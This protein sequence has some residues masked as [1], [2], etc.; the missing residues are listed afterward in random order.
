M[1]ATFFLLAS[2]ALV[3]LSDTNAVAQAVAD[4]GANVLRVEQVDGSEWNDD[5]PRRRVDVLPANLPFRLIAGPAARDLRV[6]EAAVETVTTSM[7]IQVRRYFSERGVLAPTVQWLLRRCKPGVTNE[8]DYLSPGAH[9]LVWRARDFDLDALAKTS[10]MMSSNSIP[11]IARLGLLYEEYKVSPIRRAEPLVDYPDPRAE[12]WC[13]TPYGIAIALRA[14]ENRRKFR[15]WASS[16]PVRDRNVNYRW[17]RLSP[18][19]ASASRVQGQARLSPEKGYAEIVLNWSEVRGR[20]DFAVFARY[21]DGPYGP[22]S[23][24]SFFVVPN[25]VRQYDRRGRIVKI[26]YR[27][28]DVLMPGLYQ[29]KPWIDVY[30]L[31]DQGRILSFLR[32]RSGAEK[33]ERFSAF[34]EFIVETH[35]NGSPKT[36]RKT[37]YFT[38]P[39]DSS[40]LDYEVTDETVGYRLGT[41][42]PR[43]RGE[44]P[45][46]KG[47][48]RKV[49]LK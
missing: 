44:F 42:E 5:N 18:G 7:P 9:P 34:G 8:T 49:G 45:I 46:V 30:E 47:R 23:M 13:E 27:K 37:R 31:D 4:Y 40:V 36:A 10:G 26:A 3:S 6:A 17:V 16:W 33:E 43:T 11:M 25:E 15:F 2:Q 29:N 21:G 38:S 14:P 39:D 22:P 12:A 24:I 19:R 41:F 35:P 28:S 32:T 1:P 48:H 20:L